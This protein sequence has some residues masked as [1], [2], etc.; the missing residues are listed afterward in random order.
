MSKSGERASSVALPQPA[1]NGAFAGVSRSWGIGLTAQTERRAAP[2]VGSFP[3]NSAY[4]LN[5][6]K[7]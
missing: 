2:T 1:A 5:G 3:L 7:A 4:R 6:M